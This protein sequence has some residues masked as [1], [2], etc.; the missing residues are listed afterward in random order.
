MKK[1]AIVIGAGSAGLIAAKELK[2]KGFEV[3]I[4][5]KNSEIGGIWTSLPWKSYTLTSSKWVTEYGCYPMPEAYPDFVTNEH[6]LRYLDSFVDAFG[7]RQV[8]EF[9]VKI[10]S[11]DKNEEGRLNIT[12]D[13]GVY[14][15]IDHVV[16][17]AGLHGEPFVPDFQGLDQFGGMVMHSSK[18][19]DPAIF[20]GRKVLCVGLGESGIGL[21]SEL[22]QVADKLV[23]SSEGVAVAPRVIKGSQNPFDQMQFWQ[24]GRYMI[25]YQELLTSGLSWFYRKIPRALKKINVTMRLKFY[26]DFGVRFEDFENWFP[27]ALV[28][29]H[30]H[31]K[32]WAKPFNSDRSGNLT[33]TDAPPDDPFYLIKTGRIVP[34]G[35]VESFDQNGSFFKD[36]SY[37][38]FDT[39]ILNTGYKPGSS[40]IA[41]PDGWQYRHLDL[42]KGCIHPTIPNL[43]FVGMVRP[44]I[45]SIPAMAEMHSRVIA[46]YFSGDVRLPSE[47]ERRKIIEQD[48]AMHQQECPHMHERFPHIYFFDEWMDRM[49]EIISARPRL[50]EHLGSLRALRAYFFGSPMPLRYRMRGPGKVEGAAE[51]YYKRVDR[52]W[53]N[54]FGKWAAATVLI[55]LATPYLLSIAAFLIALSGFGL[56]LSVAVL[57]GV[58]FFLAYRFIDL[59]RYLFEVGIART[60]SILSGIFFI[61]ELKQEAPDYEQPKIFQ[62]V[63]QGE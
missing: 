3:K 48:N 23:I 62:V 6:M 19:D 60:L 4:L 15:N 45:G 24:I 14:E 27:K 57:C 63:E 38:E 47:Q 34:K 30:F 35:R 20:K 49:A 44:T 25:G 29:H 32:F 52:V 58:L 18:Y 55:H 41:F 5:D 43:A 61:R 9:N 54:G 13:R 31:V 50:R 21:M 53:G 16:V 46:A 10:R 39:I 37:D 40:S 7:L 51:T 36:G 56:P 22:A 11:I 1:T 28:P 8:I 12:T 2:E 42:F 17:S 59:F 26:S 33:R